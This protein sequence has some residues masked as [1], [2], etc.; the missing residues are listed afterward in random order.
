[1]LTGWQ[2]PFRGDFHIVRFWH[3]RTR[4]RI[5]I[6]PDFADPSHHS[7][8]QIVDETEQRPDEGGPNEEA[9]TWHPAPTL[10]RPERSEALL[11]QVEDQLGAAVVTRGRKSD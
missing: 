10:H 1:M 2:Q 4:Y 6:V 5:T 3:E 11:K 9:R 8:I 7:R